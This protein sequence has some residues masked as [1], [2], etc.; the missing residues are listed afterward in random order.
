MIINKKKRIKT[1]DKEVNNN[2]KEEKELNNIEKIINQLEYTIKPEK[3][4]IF[5]K[6][7][8]RNK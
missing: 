7:G 6:Y 4:R 2:M 5:K 3:N 1:K 8:C